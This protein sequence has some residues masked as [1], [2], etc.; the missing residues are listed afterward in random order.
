[1]ANLTPHLLPSVH[2]I[3]KGVR[4]PPLRPTNTMENSASVPPCPDYA[5]LLPRWPSY[6]WLQNP[7]WIGMFPTDAAFFPVAY[8]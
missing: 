8:C 5:T 6:G 3:P 2:Q 4:P 1:M 7:A